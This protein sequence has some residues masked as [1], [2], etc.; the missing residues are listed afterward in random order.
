MHPQISPMGA[1]LTGF[2]TGKNQRHLR[3]KPYVS[4]G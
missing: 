2:C 4:S 3:I 1:D